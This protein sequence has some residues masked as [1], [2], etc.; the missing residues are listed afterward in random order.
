MKLFQC[1]TC[2]FLVYFENT[3]CQRCGAR[4][5][6]VPEHAELRTLEAGDQ[7][8]GWR[9]RGGDGTLYRYCANA[10]HN[11]CNWLVEADSQSGYCVSCDLN[12]TI[13]DLSYRENEVR[14]AKLEASKRRLVY[15][16]LRLGL[17]VS[18]K[19]CGDSEGLAFDF[20]ADTDLDEPVLTGHSGGL[21][22]INIAEA[23]D[24]ER[25]RRR[26]AMGEPYRTLLG[27]FRHEVGHYWWDRL[28]RDGGKLDAFRGM[29]GDER[30]D[31]EDALKSHY[32][33]GPPVDWQSR[34]VSAYAS[35]HAWE[36]FAETWAHYLHIVD[37]LETA[38]AFGL[39]T[40]PGAAADESLNVIVSFDPYLDGPFQPIIDAWLPLTFAVNSLNRSMGQAD[41][42]P[43][44][45]A[46]PAI[47][48]LSFVHDLVHGRG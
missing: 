29:F 33:N 32:R 15:A 46:A 22:T 27:H 44:V 35:S 36:D 43:F 41:L 19:S 13:P 48:K 38:G 16:L 11:V 3:A 34:F 2:G 42:Y 45:L 8:N 1:H 31:Y 21:I 30:P 17:P 26:T 25:E 10:A 20:K 12:R 6:F 40:R 47:G 9:V 5:G 18:S 7:P 24:A 14:W 39:Q 37:T 4:L 28:V 23:D